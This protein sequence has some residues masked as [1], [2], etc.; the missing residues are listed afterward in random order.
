MQL[1]SVIIPTY[2]R[3]YSIITAVNSVLAQSYTSIEVI[4]VD[5]GSTDNTENLIKNYHE[6]VT[7]LYKDNGGVSS[8]RNYGIQYSKG[9][10][11]A[12]LDSDDIWTLCKIEKQVS[13]LNQNRDYGMV[14]TDV[15]MVDSSG[16][17]NEKSNRRL[18]FP[19]DGYILDKVLLKPSLIPSSILVRRSVL[20][21]VGFFDEN[22]KTAEDLDLHLRIAFK[23]KI[24]LITE[25]LVYI[26]KGG[27]G[28]SQTYSTYEDYV[29]VIEKFLKNNSTLF[30][31]NLRN[32]ALYNAYLASSN[33]NYWRGD[34]T[35]GAKFAFY[36]M[37][38][39]TSIRQFFLALKNILKV[40]KYFKF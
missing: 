18:A 5:D 15:Y 23:Y 22:L 33:G 8:A 4:V 13:W 19:D 26:L 30:C 17:M 21:D 1:V 11:I 35:A 28:L 25:P 31:R 29:F 39:I 9:D 16:M 37:K 12:F 38:K 34:I 6:K 36:S 10:L 14:L 40:V 20:D 2:N 7:Y 32:K 3:D 24:G 27:E